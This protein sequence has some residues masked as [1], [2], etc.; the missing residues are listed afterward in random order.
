VAVDRMW[1]F[2]WHIHVAVDRMWGLSWH[3]HVA[4]DHNAESR[5]K[6]E[7][8]TGRNFR[9]LPSPS[10]KFIFKYVTRTPPKFDFLLFQPEWSP[11]YLRSAL[12]IVSIHVY[13]N[14]QMSVILE[15]I[16]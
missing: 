1:G 10:P 15:W 11:I 2:S 4:V 16:I 12:T 5:G 7:V 6:T 13:F 8:C 14:A 3:I 9:T